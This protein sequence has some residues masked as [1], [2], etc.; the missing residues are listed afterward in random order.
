M[1]EARLYQGYDVDTVDLHI[2]DLAADL[3]V[4]QLCATNYDAGRIDQVKPCIPEVDIL[5]PGVCER[6]TSNREPVRFSLVK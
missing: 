3:D 5:E 2:A 1:V 6:D 4:H